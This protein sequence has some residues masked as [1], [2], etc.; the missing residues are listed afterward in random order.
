MFDLTDGVM[1]GV[2][3]TKTPWKE[4]FFLAVKWARQKLSKYLT[5]VTPSTGMLLIAAYI[6]NSFQQLGM[7][8][9]WE[10]GMDINPDDE[11]FYTTQY[12]E[13]FLMYLENEYCA[14]HW[15]VPVNKHESLQKSN[16]TLSETVLASC[17]SSFDP[18]DLSSNDE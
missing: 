16:L 14:K 2:S 4:D 17:Q 11:T 6:I 5:E 15:R 7:F 3:K 10:T 12:Q 18:Y 9:K 1:R 13:T 8:R